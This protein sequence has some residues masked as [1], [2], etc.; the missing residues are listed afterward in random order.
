M[1]IFNIQVSSNQDI[2]LSTGTINA[3]IEVT[4]TL[5]TPITLTFG[6]SQKYD[7]IIKKDGKEITRWSK[8]KMF[9]MLVT[10]RSLEP[11]EK[12]AFSDEIPLESEKISPGV[13]TLE[14]TITANNIELD[15]GTRSETPVY[16]LQ[17][18]RGDIFELIKENPPYKIDKYLEQ[19]VGAWP[20]HFEVKGEISLSRPAKITVKEIQ[21]TTAIWQL[22]YLR[23]KENEGGQVLCPISHSFNHKSY[24]INNHWR[25]FRI[26]Q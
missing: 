4:N 17:T 20:N 16:Y 21:A 9:N 19:F 23:Q 26:K 8:G 1:M 12:M 14:A 15:F 7:F 2:Y 3:T 10:K 11:T 25:W 18:I 5:S 24:S 6:S 13:Y 22:D